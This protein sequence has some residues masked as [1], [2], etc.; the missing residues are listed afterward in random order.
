MILRSHARPLFLSFFIALVTLLVLLAGGRSFVAAQVAPEGPPVVRY[1]DDVD[2]P[3][4]ELPAVHHASA[5][6]AEV[7]TAVRHHTLGG[8]IRA[9]MRATQI[10]RNSNWEIYVYAINEDGR[11]SDAIVTGRDAIDVEPS[12]RRGGQEIAY[13][14]NAGDDYEIRVVDVSGENV[15]TLTSNDATDA[16]PAFSPDG[17]LIAFVSDRDGQADIYTMRPDG[18]HQKRLTDSPAYDGHPAWSPDGTQ[19]VFSSRRT[20]GYRIFVMDADGSN[21]RQLSDEPVSIRPSWSPDGRRIVYSADADQDGWLDLRI[22]NADGSD[23]RGLRNP[24]GAVDAWADDWSPD[25]GSVIY[26][27]ITYVSYQG[28]WYIQRAESKLVGME[29]DDRAAAESVSVFDFEPSW[30]SL[31]NHV[32]ETNVIALPQQSPATFTVTWQGSDTGGAGL[33]VYNVQMRIDDGPWQNWIQG[34]RQ[35]SAEVSGLA[36]QRFAFRS[37]ARDHHYNIEPWPE[38]PDAVTTIETAPPVSTLASLPTTM[39]AGGRFLVTPHGHDPGGSGIAAHDIEYGVDSGPWITG[40]RV[41]PGEGWLFD[42]QASGVDHGVPIA[43]RT[44]ASDNAGN[45][46]AWRGQ[47]DTTTM[48][49][50]W[51]VSGYVS[52]NTGNPSARVVVEA[53]PALSNPSGTGVH[54]DFSAVG[55]E[56]ATE[57]RL[58]WMKPGYGSPTPTLFATTIDRSVALVMPPSNDLVVDGGFEWPGHP[59]AGLLRAFCRYAFPVRPEPQVRK[60]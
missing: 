45:T 7:T 8:D 12:A 5:S 40:M 41:Q 49:Y 33:E 57:A 39:R 46:E 28:Q 44:R 58:H 50:P 18:S 59:R 52:D 43:F 14:S 34:T 36:G 42:P 30:E 9:S 29:E 24:S 15:R 10:L 20:G 19:I 51:R 13:S 38:T 2:R 32:P 16:Q 11:F 4:V 47:A 21:Q 54:G 26:T 6:A 3:V 22:M 31:D 56:V 27:L 55:G 48:L 25:N 53:D 60:V 23:Q 17:S 1:S 35:T 37:R